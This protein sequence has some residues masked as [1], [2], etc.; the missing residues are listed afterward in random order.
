VA[1]FWLK[2]LLLAAA[3]LVASGFGG[4]VL[5]TGRMKALQSH[6]HAHRQPNTFRG[7]EARV[8]GGLLLAVGLAL[9]L[10]AVT[11]LATLD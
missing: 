7:K 6:R 1:A 2:F 9:L 4:R 3:G 8:R 5:A 11:L 10:A